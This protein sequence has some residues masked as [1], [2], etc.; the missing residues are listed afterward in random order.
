MDVELK[1]PVE[2]HHRII[3]DATCRD[4]G[5]VRS[6]FAGFDLL[7]PVTVGNVSAGGKYVSYALS[8]RLADREEMARV[9][10][11]IKSVPGI[12]MCL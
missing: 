4:D 5:K 11:A 3:I 6:L 7:E 9:D 12:K 1:F 8:V 2:A 10:A